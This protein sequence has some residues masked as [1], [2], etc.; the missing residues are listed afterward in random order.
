ML[1][2]EAIKFVEGAKT[3][4]EALVMFAK[5]ASE[6]EYI[7]SKEEFLN[8][9][10]GREEEFSTGIGANVAVP[11]CKSNTV[12]KA[13]VLVQKFSNEIHW[14]ALDGEPVKLAIC[15]AIPEEE[16]GTTHIKLLSNIARSLINKEFVHDLLNANKEEELLEKLISVISE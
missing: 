8:G 7:N 10:L 1:N 12:K 9:L 16:A 13:T 2:L 11:H 4:Q 3:K 5:M 14:G 6:L 15:L